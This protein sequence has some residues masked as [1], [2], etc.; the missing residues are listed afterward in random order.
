M[1]E[2]K[3][4]LEEYKNLVRDVNTYNFMTNLMFTSAKIGWDGKLE[5]DNDIICS[6]MQAAEPETFAAVLEELK[7][8]KAADHDTL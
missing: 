8:R 1:S 3:I 7:G 2:I 5:F 4:S 6:I